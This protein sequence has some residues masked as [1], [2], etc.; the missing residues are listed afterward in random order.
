MR[1]GDG[2]TDGKLSEERDR[3]EQE[4]SAE[5]PGQSVRSPGPGHTTHLARKVDLPGNLQS[6]GTMGC[7]TQ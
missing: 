6:Q 2:Y 7:P 5:K 1:Q 3:N 4:R